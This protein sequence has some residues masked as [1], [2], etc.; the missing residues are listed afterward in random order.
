MSVLCCPQRV[1]SG[2]TSGPERVHSGSI[3]T[4][5]PSSRK[6]WNRGRYFCSMEETTSSDAPS[7][8][9]LTFRMYAMRSP[10]RSAPPSSPYLFPPSSAPSRA[11]SRRPSQQPPWRPGRRPCFPPGSGRCP[12]GSSPTGPPRPPIERN[13][14][15]T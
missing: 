8:R 3:Q 9:P 2:S 11:A 10:S 14:S 4:R 6:P 5:P 1:R 13:N 12:L 7:M 15:F